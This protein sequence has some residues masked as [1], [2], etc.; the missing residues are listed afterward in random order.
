MTIE[1]RTTG[2]AVASSAGTI[3]ITNAGDYVVVVATNFNTAGTSIANAT[4]NSTVMTKYV[5]TASDFGAGNVAHVSI[6]GMFTQSTGSLSY[7]VGIPSGASAVSAASF[8]SVSLVTQV[9][10]SQ[11][12]VSTVGASAG[13]LSVS[14][15]LNGRIAILGAY[16]DGQ[17]VGFTTGTGDIE[18]ADIDGGAHNRHFVEYSSASSAVY[19]LSWT[20][21]SEAYAHVLM[22]LIESTVNATNA[23]GRMITFI[24]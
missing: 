21:A 7:S 8:S 19:T 4:F 24:Q 9:N 22:E 23:T 14:S 11:S 3:T 6:F 15:G 5:T 16:G 20:R 13:S 17:T 12:G 1:L 2:G 10:S 18:I